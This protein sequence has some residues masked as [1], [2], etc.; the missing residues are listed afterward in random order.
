[1]IKIYVLDDVGKCS[2][3]HETTCELFPYASAAEAFAFYNQTF[4]VTELIKLYQ[5]QSKLYVKAEL[6]TGPSTFVLSD[7]NP[8]NGLGS[9]LDER[10]V[11]LTIY[12]EV[13][14]VLAS[15]RHTKSGRRNC[16]SSLH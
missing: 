5:S 10:G 4:N 2:M 16:N 12:I 3:I 14:D 6:P 7:R 9:E 15:N 8:E 1:M 13:G 11:K